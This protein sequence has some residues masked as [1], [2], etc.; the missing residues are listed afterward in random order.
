MDAHLRE[1]IAYAVLETW[2]RH[3]PIEM[4]RLGLTFHHANGR[5]YCDQHQGLFVTDIAASTHTFNAIESEVTAMGPMLRNEQG[6]HFVLVSAAECPALVPSTDDSTTSSE[7]M[8]IRALRGW[9]EWKGM[10][11]FLFPIH[12]S[13]QFVT[14]LGRH[15]SLYLTLRHL[16]A[17]NYARVISL[18]KCLASELDVDSS[19]SEAET[20]V[21]ERFDG[22]CKENTGDAVACRLWL[23]LAV[24]RGAPPE[25][26]KGCNLQSDL[27]LYIDMRDEV[28]AECRLPLVDELALLNSV[29]T[30]TMSL[31]IKRKANLPLKL[32]ER[33]ALL[34]A[35]LGVD[36]PGNGPDGDQLSIVPHD[37]TSTI[38]AP[39][40][41][42]RLVE[43]VPF[44]RIEFDDSCAKHSPDI[45]NGMSRY[46][47][48]VAFQNEACVNFFLERLLKPLSLH[49]TEDFAILYEC[50]S[51]AVSMKVLPQDDAQYFA[52]ILLYCCTEKMKK[53][54]WRQSVLRAMAH[55]PNIACEIPRIYQAGTD[56]WEASPRSVG[57]EDL[58]PK[59][60][61]DIFLGKTSE[62]RL[63]ELTRSTSSM[64]HPNGTKEKRVY[65]D[66]TRWKDIASWL[67]S[68][69]YAK[70]LIIPGTAPSNGQHNNS[71]KYQ[72]HITFKVD[73]YGQLTQ[74]CDDD[75]LVGGEFKQMELT[76]NVA[77]GRMSQH[78]RST[79]RGAQ[80]M[81]VDRLRRVEF[82][83][84]RDRKV[85]STLCRPLRV[86]R[87]TMMDVDGL[88]SFVDLSPVVVSDVT[89]SVVS[90]KA[91]TSRALQDA[92]RSLKVGTSTQ[93]A[94]TKERLAVDV[95]LELTEER[96]LVDSTRLEH[97]LEKLTALEEEDLDDYQQK[98]N[99][100]CALASNTS[101]NRYFALAQM[102][103]QEVTITLRLLVDQIVAYGT[104]RK[105]TRFNPFLTQDTIQTMESLLIQA[106]LHCNRVGQTRRSICGVRELLNASAADR[107]TKQ[108]LSDRCATELATKRWHLELNKPV[109]PLFVVYEWSTNIVLRQSQVE[110]LRTLPEKQNVGVCQQILMGMGKTTVLLP[111]LALMNSPDKLN[112]VTVPSALLNF[113]LNVQRNTFSCSGAL[114]RLVSKFT[115]QRGMEFTAH[116]AHIFDNLRCSNGVIVTTPT[117]IKSLF[118]RFI[119]LMHRFDESHN[120]KLETRNALP[121]GLLRLKH[122]VLTQLA[123]TR[124]VPAQAPSVEV[125]SAT[126]ARAV[127]AEVDL[128]SGLHDMFR[129][130]G[131]VLLDEVDTILH[132]LKS[133]LNWPT[134]SKRA[135][136]L[137]LGGQGYDFSLAVEECET[138]GG[139]RWLLP[140]HLIDGLLHQQMS[141]GANSKQLMPSA[142]VFTQTSKVARVV[143]ANIEKCLEEGHAR[144]YVQRVPHLVLLDEGFYHR[145]L[146]PLLATWLGLWLR[147]QHLTL[148]D[149]ELRVYLLEP[150]NAP[151]SEQIKTYMENTLVDDQIQVLNLAKLWLSSYLPFI[152]S[153]V[154]RVRFGLL[155]EPKAGDSRGLLAVPFVGKDVPCEGSE[156]SHPD[157]VIGLTILAYRYSGLR[158]EDVKSIIKLL[159]TKMRDE[160]PMPFAE[161]STSKLYERWVRLQGKRVRGWAT[162]SSPPS[163]DTDENDDNG[164]DTSDTADNALVLVAEAR[165]HQTLVN[166]DRGM[167]GDEVPPLHHLEEDDEMQ[168]TQLHRLLR[169][170]PFVQSWYL[171]ACVFPTTT[172]HTD[173]VISASGQEIGSSF[174]FKSRI[175][176]SGTPSDLLPI[177]L[178]PC[179]YV[180]GDDAHILTTLTDPGVCDMHVLSASWSAREVLDYVIAHQ[181]AALI[182]AGALITGMSNKQVAEY[183]V[184]APNT[185][186]RGV[187]YLDE[188]DRVLVLLRAERGHTGPHIVRSLR[189]CGLPTS[190]RFTFYDQVHTLGMDIDQ[191]PTAC[192]VVTLGKAANFRDV[193]QGAFRMRQLGKGQKVTILTIPEVHRQIAT[194]TRVAASAHHALEPLET[195]MVWA[196]ANQ[197]CAEQGQFELLALQILENCVRKQCFDRIRAQRHV[198][199]HDDR[200]SSSRTP[201]IDDLEEH[202]KLL[203]ALDLFRLRVD[204]TIANVVQSK[205][206]DRTCVLRTTRERIQ[207]FVEDIKDVITDRT[208]LDHA[209]AHIQSLIETREESTTCGMFD[210][211]ITDELAREQV[212][213][214]QHEVEHEKVEEKEQEKERE[215]QEVVEPCT[216]VAKLRYTRTEEW[217]TAWP[218]QCLSMSPSHP[219]SPFYPLRKFAV[220]TKLNRNPHPISFPHYLWVSENFYRRRWTLKT[221]RRLKNVNVVLEMTPNVQSVRLFTPSELESMP[222]PEEQVKTIER[223]FELF[224]AENG[225]AHGGDGI[226]PTGMRTL[227][228][229]MGFDASNEECEQLLARMLQMRDPRAKGSLTF[230]EIGEVFRTQQY[231]QLEKGRYFVCVS[232]HEA[233]TLRAC[234]HAKEHSFVQP[235]AAFVLR[236]S[237]R[238]WSPCAPLDESYGYKPG[239]SDLQTRQA[240]A[241]FSFFNCVVEPS[242]GEVNLLVKAL[243][244]SRTSERLRWFQEI[245][246]CR[247]RPRIENIQTSG[248]VR[249]F[250]DD[251]QEILAIR[252]IGLLTKVKSALRKRDLMPDDAFHRF[253]IANRGS[254]SLADL[255]LGLTLLKVKSGLSLQEASE[256]FLLIDGRKHGQILLSQWRQALEEVWDDRDESAE[257]KSDAD[258]TTEDLPSSSQT[259]DDVPLKE[260]IARFN[261]MLEAHD[262]PTLTSYF[263]PLSVRPKDVP[264][265][266]LDKVKVCI[267]G[268][269]TFNK[270]WTSEGTMTR[271]FCSIWAPNCNRVGNMFVQSKRRVRLCLGHVASNGPSQPS[272]NRLCC[273]IEFCDFSVAK[274]K[275]SPILSAVVNHYCPQPT[276]WRLAWSQFRG[277]QHLYVWMP[278]P[279]HAS[280]VAVGMVCTTSPEP[281]P[282]TACRC[283]P[284]KWTSPSTQ[285]PTHVW[286]NR[287]V[288]GKGG[289]I[290]S[291]GAFCLVHAHPQDNEA[292]KAG[293]DV[294]R[295]FLKASDVGGS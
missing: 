90:T 101:N 70:A 190:A 14:S 52:R 68:Q 202:A 22:I 255:W 97:L 35:L 258:D 128:L 140:L 159:L 124:T 117:S 48:P 253:D 167:A 231:L 44:E 175:G 237:L 27:M 173:T 88:E 165:C 51:A 130:H 103:S 277:K 5:L 195:L 85:A 206:G 66:R 4:P 76:D 240:M 96:W 218:V 179:Q 77:T 95:G 265:D 42:K 204:F 50:L 94:K 109:N 186:F 119:F 75:G 169:T 160:T 89:K 229:C 193:G 132:P 111:M 243:C 269:Y 134:G 158:Q 264:C 233:E 93:A 2:R 280:Y 183:I 245:Q 78:P 54:S 266:V 3:T 136:D 285:A 271:Q 108:V 157:V 263:D 59:T 71:A 210:G 33:N 209:L 143:L 291:V 45:Y 17:K 10:G 177:S 25:I 249:V 106:L 215:M 217:P 287:G 295:L 187:V 238:K 161:R 114:P 188:H 196:L 116:M 213:E 256:L 92:I 30:N 112:I 56:S 104:L 254:I 61:S 226:A 127:R 135:L 292:P 69:Y 141:C 23:R 207:A 225:L 152:I 219:D 261:D 46:R 241:C 267:A 274:G 178:G 129:T 247:R 133:E 176:F 224:A 63:A 191:A 115:F 216:M 86:Q 21:A 72:V 232:L 248:L 145:E 58:V 9:R 235:D 155:D 279:P 83:H 121:T 100:V 146:K 15:A 144:C 107:E 284:K 252:R 223:T 289:S 166:W 12:V 65:A 32:A 198:V 138:F 81:P 60:H 286:D 236:S 64:L 6:D 123:S 40:C 131:C 99:N 154:N 200:S 67:N 82:E 79:T 57:A 38:T 55:N 205:D 11:T 192:A 244:Q 273:V 214:Q 34:L 282:F 164:G 189:E 113:T 105:L 147:H 239:M 137:T 250:A 110:H 36:D 275:E 197:L 212:T 120:S 122:K 150:A 168:M 234:M 268:P 8:H 199:G 102:A 62:Q 262:L 20:Q 293:Y 270:I 149:D 98:A 148:T 29:D 80:G 19:L 281:P 171:H 222:L 31:A 227:L 288:G 230:E 180:P 53:K 242:T 185:S 220:K 142:Y 84:I 74:V 184:N 47:S 41:A 283:V 28:S 26:A 278:I 162:A 156:Y 251:E 37:P 49:R 24:M 272:A 257:E 139:N 13:G 294:N 1:H 276:N 73:E 39:L 181:Y 201:A 221:Y 259:P 174:L 228:K 7:G 118:L 290:W 153:H 126:E 172:I 91:S 151:I 208:A 125:L 43:G 170:S 194:D 211:E 203:K 18:S 16:L 260:E 182:D 163:D 246:Q 87:E